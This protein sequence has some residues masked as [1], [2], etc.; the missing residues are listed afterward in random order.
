MEYEKLTL[1][2]DF[3][4][5]KVMQNESLCKKLLEIILN[6]KIDKLVY[7]AE[8]KVFDDS[9]DGK[10]VRLDVYVEDDKKTVFDIEMQT[11]DTKELPKRSRYYQGRID[12]S[13]LDKGTEITYRN[14]KP[15][16][17]IFICMHDIFGR[18]RHYYR[19]E[20]I[21]VDDT[22]IKLND[23][24]VKIFLNPDSIMDDIDVELKNFLKYLKTGE[25]CDNFTKDLNDSVQF[26]RYNKEWKEEYR[27]VDMQ[28]RVWEQDAKE[29]GLQEGLKEGLQE[30]LKEGKLAMALKYISRGKA[31]LEEAADDLGVPISEIENALEKAGLAV[32]KTT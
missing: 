30:G 9:P 26:A 21:C 5:A 6:I 3:I 25:T 14:L 16:Y 1:S 27:M 19:F 18:G 29:K 32:P 12:V 2:N 8:Q 11:S 15:S 20:N 23:E 17:I 10:A 4:F 13:I 24:A 7:H 22:T 31:T 28:R